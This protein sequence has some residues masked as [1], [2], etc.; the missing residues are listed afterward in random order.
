MQEKL[1]I[2]ID[3]LGRYKKSNDEHLF[4]CPYCE[5]S[6]HKFSVNIDKNVYKC[7][8]C[9]TRGRNLKRVVRRFGT[10]KQRQAW[11]Q[12]TDEVDLTSF[13]SIFE[14]TVETKVEQT[15]DLPKEFISLANTNLPITAKPAL[16]YLKERGVTKAD[17]L[18]WKIGYCSSGEYENRIIFPSFNKD[19]YVNYFVARTYIDHW[20]RYLNPPV[21][22]NVLFNE[23][24]V[25]WNNDLCIVEGV[26]DAVVASNAIPLLGSSLRDSSK[27]L[28]K[29]IKHDTP[30]YL[31]MDPDAKDKEQK[32][33]KL[34][35][36]Y[37]IEL[38][39]IDVSG[40]EDIGEM[41]KEQFNIRKEK[42]E[43]IHLD[44]YL[45]YEALNA[46]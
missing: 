1:Q 23:L 15:I 5:H 43:F 33:A 35:M 28:Q 46:I 16:K 29:I 18:K 36:Q 39:K 45:L 11:D 10:F 25:D 44:N 3:V 20:K 27:L 38:Y 26:F 13:D 21:S 17:I 30:I 9:D 37:D 19:G 34:L 4:R 6:K 24:Y 40:F 41:T 22:N 12:L 42:A 8:I 2:L 32:I 31:A 14:S 7:W